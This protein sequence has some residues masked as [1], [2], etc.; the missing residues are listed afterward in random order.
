MPSTGR[1]LGFFAAA[2]FKPSAFWLQIAS[3]IEA[4]SAIG[5][6]SSIRPVSA[7]SPEST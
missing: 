1:A 3:R 5:S 7:R 4:V 2:K 6:S